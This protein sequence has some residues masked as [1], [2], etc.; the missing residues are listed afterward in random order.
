MF[1][2]IVVIVVL[3]RI[4]VET[5]IFFVWRFILMF[6]ATKAN[7]AQGA[8]AYKGAAKRSL[9]SLLDGFRSL[10]GRARVAQR[11]AATSRLLQQ[12][13]VSSRVLRVCV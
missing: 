13:H 5:F 9:A 10:T 3:T 7:D 6:L 4:V 8:A 2:N 12:I 1:L 11:M